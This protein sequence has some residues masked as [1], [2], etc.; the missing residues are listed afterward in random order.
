MRL[1]INID[2]TQYVID[3]TDPELLGKWVI[4]IFGRAIAGGITQATYI[5]MQAY[6]SWI[7]DD[8]NGHPDW[9]ADSRIIGNVYEVRA[10]EDIVRILG[11]QIKEY[12]AIRD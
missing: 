4:E 11:E 8:N 1:S 9:I 7:P 3:S 6:P 5:T 2:N 12:N 10:P